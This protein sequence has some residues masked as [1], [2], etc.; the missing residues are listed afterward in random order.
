[1]KSATSP[2]EVKIVVGGPHTRHEWGGNVG[3]I[4]TDACFDTVLT[5]HV[6]FYGSVHTHCVA[7]RRWTQYAAQIKLGSAYVAMCPRAC[8]KVGCRMQCERSFILQSE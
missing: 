4:N 2:A 7:I 8:I 5:E 3:S 1:M 6:D